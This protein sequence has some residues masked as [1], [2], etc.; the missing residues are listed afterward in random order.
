MLQDEIKA[1][2]KRLGMTQ[3][4]FAEAL[5]FKS[6]QTISNLESGRNVAENAIL[7]RLAMAQLE[8]TTTPKRKLDAKAIRAEQMKR[9]SGGGR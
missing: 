5:G 9:W 1:T 2:R 3:V 7:L 8:Q 6:S 4:E